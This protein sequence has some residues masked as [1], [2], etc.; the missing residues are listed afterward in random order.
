M[1]YCRTLVVPNLMSQN[2]TIGTALNEFAEQQ[3]L[4]PDA[5]F[6][7]QLS[8]EELFTNVVH[9]AHDD[10]LEHDVEIIFQKQGR[11]VTIEISDGGQPFNPLEDAPEP[12][13]DAT[14]EERRIGGV[15]VVLAKE[16]MTEL[17]YERDGG[18]N[19]MIMIKKI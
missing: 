3:N 13:I 6:Q 15:G 11:T 18:H 4:P 12:D 1:D 14:L 9:Y 16:L 8:L 5:V 19:R 10:D 2:K 17:R 7:I